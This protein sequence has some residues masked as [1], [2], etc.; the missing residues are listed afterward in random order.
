MAGSL[1][2]RISLCRVSITKDKDDKNTLWLIRKA[3][4]EDGILKE[5]H[6]VSGNKIFDNRDRLF[7]R[8]GSDINGAFGIWKWSAVPNENNPA[9]DYVEAN[10][11]EDVQPLEII[12]IPSVMTIEKLS[13]VMTSSGLDIAPVSKR[14]LLCPQNTASLEYSGLLCSDKDFSADNGRF[15]LKDSVYNLPL[16]SFSSGD[17]ITIDGKIFY[18]SLE[19]GEPLRIELIKHP[20]EIVRGIILQRIL[21]SKV[22]AL[23][24]PEITKS[25]WKYI[26]AFIT[27]MPVNSIYQEIQSTCLCSEDE[28]RDYA[29]SF[30]SQAEK[31]IDDEDYDGIISSILENCPEIRG[32]L[33]SAIYENWHIG[34][35]EKINEAEK[36]IEALTDELDSKKNELSS[37]KA[38]L[39]ELQKRIQ[40]Q[41]QLAEDVCMKVQQ[42]ISDARKDAANF[43]AEMSF[44]N[45]N[46]ENLALTPI[47]YSPGKD[48]DSDDIEYADNWQQLLDSLAGELNQAG[49]AGK[50]ARKFSAFLYSAYIHHVP[51][52]MAGPNGEDIADAFSVSLFGKTA[53]VADCS[54]SYFPGFGCDITAGNDDV[55]IVK[56][57]FRSEWITH[58]PD[59]QKI[60]WHFIVHPFAEDLVIEPKSLFTY[61]LPVFT[62]LI[63]D[64]PPK[65][66]YTAAK[67]SESYKEYQPKKPG[68]IHNSLLKSL[69]FTPYAGLKVQAVL[70]VFHRLTSSEED[71]DSDCLFA[72]FPYAFL[73]YSKR[74]SLLEKFSGIS[75]EL[76]KEL[77]AF[78]GEHDE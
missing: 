54:V 18:M 3:D 65:G 24:L 45:P 55:F 76:R 21:P 69:G 44:M 1:I 60:G 5:F 46:R 67:C 50:Y 22:K 4:I 11:V 14:F 42:R 48:C 7:W 53:G 2:E 49:V 39:E 47:F 62:E 31:Y 51:I 16:Y 25:K 8:N 64:S 74:D 72:L 38:T 27:G 26:R 23:N 73:T 37:V 40:S 34:N 15:V 61:S 77:S 32:K 41:E 35:Q 52:L 36:K 17:T 30:F 10:Y 59:F 29:D 20:M 58:I 68:A 12:R 28:A 66:D 63:I 57:V 78:M 13:E 75:S 33:E 43:I 19:C 9:K 56:H 6:P 70:D 71:K